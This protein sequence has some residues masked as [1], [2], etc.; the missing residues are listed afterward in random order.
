MGGFLPPEAILGLER[1]HDDHPL[2][3]D[4]GQWPKCVAQHT[5]QPPYPPSHIAGWCPEHED[6]ILPGDG[7]QPVKVTGGLVA[8]LDAVKHGR[9]KEA[10]R[11]LLSA[12][13]RR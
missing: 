7:F 11:W 8:E 3:R 13:R 5:R 6:P 9:P 2:Q 1:A 10:L 12:R 4:R